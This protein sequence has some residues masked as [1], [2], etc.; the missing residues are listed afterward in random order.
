MGFRI[1]L[2][3]CSN[4]CLFVRIQSNEGWRMSVQLL[5]HLP[6]IRVI[7]RGRMGEKSTRASFEVLGYP[8]E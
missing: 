5:L 7:I 4:V 6:I 2:K 8:Y 3:C 1:T